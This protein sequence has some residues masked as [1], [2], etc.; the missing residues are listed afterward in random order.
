MFNF[1]RQDSPPK[2]RVVP[3]IP[4]LKE[5]NVRKGFIEDAGFSQL[6]A[7]ATELWLRVFLEVAFTY[8]W[9]KGELLALRVRQLNFTSRTI[10]LDVGTTKN[11]EGREVVMTA[12]VAEL[13]RQAVEG[14]GP[15]SFVLTREDGKPVK[16]FRKTWQNLCGRAGLGQFVCR[17]CE[18]AVTGRKC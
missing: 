4:M 12:K 13:L 14:K 6:A 2:V 8:G 15:D 16:D 17:N 1:G 5:D 18:R 10:R 9:R 7:Q 3:Y 11:R